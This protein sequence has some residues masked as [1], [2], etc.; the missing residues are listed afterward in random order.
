MY[1]VGVQGLGVEGLWFLRT[2]A[3]GGLPIRAL[4][5]GVRV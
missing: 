4:D 2:R 5:S 3:I 1:G